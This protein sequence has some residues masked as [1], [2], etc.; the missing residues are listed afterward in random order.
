RSGDRLKIPVGINLGKNFD[1]T[2][3][4]AVDDYRKVFRHLSALGDYFVVNVS[5]PNTPGLRDLQAISYLKP[6]LSALVE[7]NLRTV[8]QPLLVKIAPDLADDDVAAV[9]RLARE[10]KL[11]GIVAGN[12]TVRRNLVPRAAPLERGGL[13]GKPQFPRTCELLKILRSELAV[14]Q[15]I[16]AAGGISDSS[17]LHECLALGANLAQIYTAFIYNGPRCASHLLSDN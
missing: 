1:T 7:E 5:S 9:G 6:L 15:A 10:L 13:S 16:I 14:E 4:Q 3:E 2:P 11:A 8:N 12:T 17:R